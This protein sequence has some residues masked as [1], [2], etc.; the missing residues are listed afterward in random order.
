[1]LGQHV[2][3]LP[4]LSLQARKILLFLLQVSMHKVS[5]IQVRLPICAIAYCSHLLRSPTALSCPIPSNELSFFPKS[6]PHSAF[7]FHEPLITVLAQEL[8]WPLL[9]KTKYR[10]GIQN[11]WQKLNILMH[12]GPKQERVFIPSMEVF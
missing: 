3:L 8:I 1:M 2:L 12:H 5:I 11:T 6:L 9:Y 4:E 10:D 7:L